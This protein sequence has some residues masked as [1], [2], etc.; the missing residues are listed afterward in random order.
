[1]VDLSIPPESSQE[2]SNIEHSN[3]GMI[4]DSSPIRD[5][6]TDPYQVNPDDGD[7]VE[8]EPTEI[9]YEGEEEEEMN[10]YVGDFSSIRPAGSLFHF[11]PRRNDFRLPRRGSRE[12]E[13]GQQ[14]ETE[15]MM[16]AVKTYSIMRG[17]EYKILESDQL[18]YATHCTQFGSGCGWN[19]RISYHRK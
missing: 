3:D 14:F 18:K 12:F 1:M 13:I 17:V 11:E 5:P 9:S 16:L 15:G 4:H 6:M 8:A 10:F 2:G 7:D 19:I